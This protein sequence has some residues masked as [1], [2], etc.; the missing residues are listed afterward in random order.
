[1]L[2]T[3]I[4]LTCGALIT[5]G[6][7]ALL[8]APLTLICALGIGAMVQIADFCAS[9]PFA[10]LDVPAPLNYIAAAATAAVI[11]VISRR[12]TASSDL[13]Q[14][15]TPEPR[16]P[17][18]RLIGAAGSVSMCVLLVVVN[19]SRPDGRLHVTVLDV[20]Q[21]DAILLQGPA[22]GRMLIDAGPD[23]DRLLVLLDQRIPTWDRR[24]DTVVLTHTHEDHVAGL[25]LLLTR[26]R[27]GAI[28]ETGMPGPGP[29]DA[30]YRASL[31]T[32]GR[33][34]RVVAA[35]DRLWLDGIRLDVV[36]PPPDSVPAS[37]PD[38][39]KEIN[40]TSIV[41]ELHFGTRDMLFTGDAEEGID[42]L[43]LAA[44]M[45]DRLGG[46]VDVLKVAHH[47][48]R[49]A[50]TVALVDAIDPVIA[51][52]SAGADNDY[53]HPT[54]E[55][56]ARLD[57]AGARTYRTDLDGSVQIT[58]DGADLLVTTEHGRP[59]PTPTPLPPTPA[60]ALLPVPSSN[61]QSRRCRFRRA[62]R[63]RQS[64]TAWSPS[65]S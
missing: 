39:G 4:G 54:P 61:L 13:S 3:V 22:G 19:G 25:A 1:M 17:S 28:A 16:P 10:T 40:D 5:I 34:T 57:A 47:G 49:T 62:P 55:T 53:G 38:S 24:I 29:S 46:Q 14:Q 35:G 33:G 45:A 7:P 2:L 30:A 42:P 32:L 27:I 44:G 63:P 26:Y 48:S 15:K 12:R 37:P 20:G 58:T 31:T 41:L 60:A 18:R 23:P 9:L 8:F 59:A 65:R 51:V 21:G 50:T 6:I 64:L 52:I 11:V 36:W 43:L 56:L